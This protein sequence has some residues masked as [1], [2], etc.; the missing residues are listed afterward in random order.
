MYNVSLLDIFDM[1]CMYTSLTSKL[2]LLNGRWQY[3]TTR[4]DY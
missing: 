2:N 4:W 1:R 3:A